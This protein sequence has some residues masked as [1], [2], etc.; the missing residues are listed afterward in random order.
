MNMRS[1]SNARKAA[2][3]GFCAVANSSDAAPVE[4]EDVLRVDA[5][6][7]R[8]EKTTEDRVNRGL[9]VDLN[10]VPPAEV[11]GVPTP[12]DTVRELV[13]VAVVKDVVEL[14]PELLV[15]ADEVGIIE[16]RDEEL[17]LTDDGVVLEVLEV[18]GREDVLRLVVL[19]PGARTCGCRAVK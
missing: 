16:V 19:S 8:V 4:D 6:D 5:V 3:K 9:E 17:L 1:A 2:L 18:L 7:V 15:S 11:L 10:D 13:G 14:S 12:G